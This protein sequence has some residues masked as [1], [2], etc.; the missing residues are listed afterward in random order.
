MQQKHYREA[1]AE[2]QQ[3]MQLR[4][5]DDEAQLFLGNLYFLVRD[6]KAALAQYEAVKSANPRLAEKLYQALYENKILRSGLSNEA[7]E[8]HNQELRRTRLF[9]RATSRTVWN[10]VRHFSRKL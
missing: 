8:I 4:P 7:L 3:T 9:Q 2:L 5:D 1:I 10:T 6:R